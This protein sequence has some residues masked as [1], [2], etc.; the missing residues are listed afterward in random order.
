MQNEKT[1]MLKSLRSFFFL[2]FYTSKQRLHIPR[3]ESSQAS[4]FFSAVRDDRG[5]FLS[6]GRTLR[7]GRLAVSVVV[8]APF[9]SGGNE[10]FVP[11]AGGVEVAGLTVVDEGTA[12]DGAGVGR[13]ARP[14]DFV[15]SRSSS[16]SSSIEPIQHKTHAFG[17]RSWETCALPFVIRLIE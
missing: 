11:N 2:Y 10:N 14:Y 9:E 6:G 8:L 15:M 13:A 3:T 12:A 5:P 16:R 4:S 7:A 17:K 1:N